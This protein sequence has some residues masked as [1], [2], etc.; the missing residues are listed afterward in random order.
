MYTYVRWIIRSG[1]VLFVVSTYTHRPHRLYLL[2]D[3]RQQLLSALVCPWSIVDVSYD[4]ISLP[5]VMQTRD[6]TEKTP[7]RATRR[8]RK[9][10]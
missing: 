5:Q 10:V 4:V 3:L 2:F 8:N 1:F 9:H 6:K 7:A